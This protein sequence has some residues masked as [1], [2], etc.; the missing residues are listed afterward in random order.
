ME[1]SA[2]NLALVSVA[3]RIR[4][5]GSFPA[6]ALNG[7]IKNIAMKIIVHADFLLGDAL[8]IKL[9]L[10]TNSAYKKEDPPVVKAMNGTMS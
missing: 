6:F 4:I 5:I 7:K 3:I 9:D 8:T 1:P 10:D 2:L